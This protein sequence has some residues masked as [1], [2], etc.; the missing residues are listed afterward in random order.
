MA[1][2]TIA[3]GALKKL[4]T[5]ASARGA[6]ADAL[7][8]AAGVTSEVLDDADA[9]VPITGLHAAWNRW[10]ETHPETEVAT[11]TAYAPSDYGIVGFVVMSSATLVEGLGHL[12]RYIGLWT[13]DP[14]FVREG[15]TVRFVY[16]HPFADSAGR[17]RATEAAPIE[18]IHGARL[19]TRS[20]VVPREVRFAHAAPDDV[21]PYAEFFGCAVH[22]GAED[23]ALVFRDE[24]LALPLANA[25]AQLGAFLRRHAEGALAKRNKE[26]SPLDG[27][28]RI[29]AEELQR[30]VPA[31]DVVA[32]RLATTERTLRRRLEREKTTF[33]ALL[34]ETR[35]DLA[36]AY[37]A[38]ASMPLAEVAFMLGFSEPS[39]F[40][41][42][43]KRWTRTTP[44][45]FRAGKPQRGRGL[46]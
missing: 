13:D 35:A 43:F 40:H 10:L 21:A 6:D 29:L 30:G 3:S 45:A 4:V 9:R 17:R 39:A 33:R 1:V 23:H 34:D 14:A 2:P 19:L 31:I 15:S 16:R 32:A 28:R 22:F 25:D 44:A 46:A 37:V 12:V 24:D 42:A 41:R 36:R 26:D 8:R 11:T 7:L 20:R 38:D 27:V 18:M 5:T